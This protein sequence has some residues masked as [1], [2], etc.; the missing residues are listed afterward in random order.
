MPF[1]IITLTVN[2]KCSEIF[3]YRMFWSFFFLIFFKAAKI[4]VV[5]INLIFFVFSFFVSNQLVLNQSINFHT[6]KMF[7]FNYL[8]GK[9]I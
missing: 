1:I 6:N 9:A 5:K 7:L 8:V 3:V 4:L 2:Q